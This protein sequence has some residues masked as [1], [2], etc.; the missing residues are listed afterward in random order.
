MFQVVPGPYFD[1]DF[2]H[3]LLGLLT[4]YIIKSEL[5]TSINSFFG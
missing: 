1:T 4:F 3:S 2:F 5:G